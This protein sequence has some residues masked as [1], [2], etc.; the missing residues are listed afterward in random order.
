MKRASTT[1]EYPNLPKPPS[2]PT[3]SHVSPAAIIKELLGDPDKC[4]CCHPSKRSTH[5][6]GS[7]GAIRAARKNVSF[8]M[9]DSEGTLFVDRSGLAFRV[10][11]DGKARPPA[12]GKALE[13][14]SAERPLPKKIRRSKKKG[15]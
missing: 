9:T 7:T 8:F 4:P 13:L 14:M 10:G 15:K 5:K 12:V 11:E 3:S 2:G 6:I 1:E